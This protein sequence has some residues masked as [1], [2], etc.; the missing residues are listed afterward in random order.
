[1]PGEPHALVHISRDVHAATARTLHNLEVGSDYA[2]ALAYQDME[3]P[4]EVLPLI[5]P[6]NLM[7]P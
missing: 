4:L 5:D 7:L 3:R 6:S 2:A 1:M